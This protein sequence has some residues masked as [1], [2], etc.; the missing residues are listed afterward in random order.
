MD[1]GDTGEGAPTYPMAIGYLDTTEL[2]SADAE[3]W[4]P[5]RNMTTDFWRSSGCFL[6][7]FDGNIYNL[8]TAVEAIDPSAPTEDEFF[9]I[10]TVG[11]PVPTALIAQGR[12]SAIDLD[13]PGAASVMLQWPYILSAL[14]DHFCRDLLEDR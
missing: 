8:R 1:S 5:Y 10:F 2:Y 4:M 11:E 7:H 3:A 9:E 13:D 14:I 12:C 6:Q